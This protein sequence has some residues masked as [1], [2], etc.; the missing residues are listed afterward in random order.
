MSDSISVGLHL[1]ERT[2]SAVEVRGGEGCPVLRRIGRVSF[3]MELTPDA[4]LKAEAQAHLAEALRELLD[5]SGVHREAVALSVGSNFF[6]I[7]RVPLEVASEEERREQIAWEAGQHLI[8]P[9][10]DYC[11]DYHAFGGTA[12]LIAIRRQMA[13]A[14]RS[15]CERAGLGLKC[16]EVDP[17]SLFYACRMASGDASGEEA[18][19]GVSAVHIGGRWASCISAW[20]TDLTAV[21]LVRLDRGG[22]RAGEDRTGT[23]EAALRSLGRRIA[24]GLVPERRNGSEGRERRVLLAGDRRVVEEVSRWWMGVEPLAVAF[25]DPFA[26]MDLRSLPAEQRPLLAWGTGLAVSAGAAYKNL[27]A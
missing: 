9:V 17:L 27:C 20:G 3:P 16:V 11:I 23:T 21:E 1:G 14:C 22:L 7:K 18:R 2:L 6:V 10:S 15:V 8:D 19:Q 13:D 26:G 5:E 12:F 4:L 25:L 24:G